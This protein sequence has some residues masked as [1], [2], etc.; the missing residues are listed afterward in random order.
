MRGRVLQ[1][2][3]GDA[4]QPDDT[5]PARRPEQAATDS[6][7][8]GLLDALRAGDDHGVLAACGD[9]TTVSAENLSWSCTG[10]DRI[11][12]ML[13]EARDRFPGLTFESRT[14]H[15]GFGLVIDEARVRDQ[16]GDAQTARLDMPVRVTVRHDDLQV[17]EVTLSFPAALL[18]RAL[19]IR[20]DPLEVSLSEVQSAFFSPVGEGL[21]T[22]SLA[23]PDLALVPPAAVE[24]TAPGAEAE[25]PKR[26][27]RRV[28]VSLAVVLVAALTVGG[29]WVVQGRGGAAVA[30]PARSTA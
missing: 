6:P 11:L 23:H 28:L 27:R 20:V 15:V 8:I 2:R 4:C 13:M 10:R 17:H 24:E 21:T 22:Y 29:W 7:G 5:G 30:G 12:T 16:T 19:G 18:K 9:T 26:R 14:R 3:P 25:Q 1:A